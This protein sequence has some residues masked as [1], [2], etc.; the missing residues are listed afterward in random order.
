MSFTITPQTGR[1]GDQAFDAKSWGRAATLEHVQKGQ[2]TLMMG[3][4]GQSVAELQTRLIELGYLPP[5]SADGRFG[6][7]TRDALARFQ[8][9]NKLATDG[10]L[11]KDTHARLFAKDAAAAPTT[12]RESD[13]LRE[14][15][16][17]FVDARKDLDTLA[18]RDP[19]RDVTANDPDSRKAR[20]D[21]GRERIARL[22]GTLGALPPAERSK[23]EQTIAELE[24]LYGALETR[25]LTGD[26]ARE[27]AARARDLE[28]RLVREL[29]AR[30]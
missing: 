21:A 1:I 19:W 17:D 7:Q 5:G 20:V 12:P 22:K 27:D 25:Y 18:A 11:G 6:P 24:R 23:A 13:A 30:R 26:G 4:G 3:H 10:M 15:V 28:T 8:G 16:R 14:R 9:A 29:P 2:T